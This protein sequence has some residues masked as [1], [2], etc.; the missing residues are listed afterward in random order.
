MQIDLNV[1]T[2]NRIGSLAN[3][4]EILRDADINIEGFST[5]QNYKGAGGIIHLLVE[6]SASSRNALEEKG[7]SISA[8]RE[9][10]VMDIEDRVGALGE[11][12]R[13][14]ADAGVNIEI[15]YLATN[16][17]LVIGT[18]DLEKARSAI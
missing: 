16:N 11:I 14:L 1:I 2:W 12:T 3:V 4:C 8:E 15:A 18:D 17:R 7:Y 13:K 6:D 10:L 9:V 5:T